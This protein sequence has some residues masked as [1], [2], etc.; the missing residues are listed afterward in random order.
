LPFARAHNDAR[1]ARELRALLANP[2][3]AR[4]AVEMAAR[5]RAVDGAAVAAQLI[6]DSMT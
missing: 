1:L 4:A 5:S 3:Y 6:I 2:A